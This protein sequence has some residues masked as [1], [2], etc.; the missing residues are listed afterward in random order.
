MT[1]YVQEDITEDVLAVIDDA[2]AV[3]NV[4]ESIFLDNCWYEIESRIFAFRNNN[5]S[6]SVFVKLLKEESV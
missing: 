5:D 2:A 1:L 4:G 6:A 3:P